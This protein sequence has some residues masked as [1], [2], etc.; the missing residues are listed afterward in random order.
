MYFTTD[1]AISVDETVQDLATQWYNQ[2]KIENNIQQWD[3]I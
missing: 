1:L 2:Q 3:F